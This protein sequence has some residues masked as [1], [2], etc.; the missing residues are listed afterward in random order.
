ME[1]RNIKV[2][3]EKAQEWYNSDNQSL[4]EIALQAFSDRELDLHWKKIKNFDQACDYLDIHPSLF[5]IKGLA[6]HFDLV[7]HLTAVYKLDVIRKALNKGFT[8][9]L[10]KNT[11]YYPLIRIYREKSKAEESAALCNG[12]LYKVQISG[13]IYHLVGGDSTYEENGITKSFV[14]SCALCD[15]NLGLLHCKSQE[16]A[17]HM[18]KYFAKE[19]FNAMYGGNNTYIFKRYE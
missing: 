8:P 12:T 15:T 7:T 17:A 5:H 18:S 1:E 14:P 10:I 2:T 3:L 16:I 19:I 13:D 9:S 4:K 11:V 6:Y